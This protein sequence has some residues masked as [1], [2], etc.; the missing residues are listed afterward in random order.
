ML[1]IEN[2]TSLRNS[3]RTKISKKMTK[4]FICACLAIITVILVTVTTL[5]FGT[6]K[7]LKLISRLEKGIYEQHQKLLHQ[8]R[9]LISL[10]NDLSTIRE[11]MH[12]KK[13]N[14]TIPPNPNV[15]ALKNSNP[16]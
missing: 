6:L 1:S 7:F 5:C 2:Q 9:D 11:S 3:P 13:C 16:A 8:A 14:C 4:F 15:E 10:E 12:H